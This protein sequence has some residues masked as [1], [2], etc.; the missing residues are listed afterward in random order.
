MLKAHGFIEGDCLVIPQGHCQGDLIEVPTMVLSSEPNTA[1]E[2][3]TCDA[4][5]LELALHLPG[6]GCLLTLAMLK[7]P[8]CKYG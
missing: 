6:F 4:T 2:H 7:Q 3:Q 5:P 8:I 1:F